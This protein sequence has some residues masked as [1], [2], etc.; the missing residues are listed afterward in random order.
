MATRIHPIT[1]N[2]AILEKLAGVP[3]GTAAIVEKIKLS[4]SSLDD[5]SRVRR[6]YQLLEQEGEGLTKYHEFV[7]FGL[8]SLNQA[9]CNVLA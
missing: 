2:A 3:A 1:S 5:A 8:S 7:T 6:F 9:A 4:C